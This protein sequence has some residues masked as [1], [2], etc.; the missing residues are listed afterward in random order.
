MPRL[1][2]VG[3]EV[4]DV[5]GEVNLV[6]GVELGPLDRKPEDILDFVTVHGSGPGW[7]GVCRGSVLVIVPGKSVSKNL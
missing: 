1:D 2:E 4:Q 5:L 3:P 7:P 6:D